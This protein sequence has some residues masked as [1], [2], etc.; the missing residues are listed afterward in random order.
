MIEQYSNPWF[1]V[2]KDGV[3]HYVVEPG[4]KNG[5]VVLVETSDSYI[6]V[7]IP[8]IAHGNENQIEAPR[9]YGK[10]EQSSLETATRELYEETGY[11]VEPLQLEKLGSVKPNS[12]ILASEVDIYL[13]RVKEGQRVKG[14]DHEVNGIMSVAKSDVRGMISRG[15]ISDSFTLSAFALLWSR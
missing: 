7:S 15:E 8:R 5:A 10:G 11:Q 6:F 3:F 4:S 13:A 9:G 14:C 1:S 2:I 12:A